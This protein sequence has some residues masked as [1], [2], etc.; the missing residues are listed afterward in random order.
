MLVVF[1]LSLFLGL[2]ESLTPDS[3]GLDWVKVGS[4]DA[5]IVSN[6]QLVTPLDVTAAAD[7]CDSPVGKEEVE[8]GFHCSWCLVK[9]CNQ[10]KVL[11]LAR[12]A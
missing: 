2:G 12:R 11:R 5:A 6:C 3:K 4:V 9:P 7:G 10:G 1:P 8:E